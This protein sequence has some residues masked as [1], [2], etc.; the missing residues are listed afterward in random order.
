MKRYARL[1][2]NQAKHTDVPVFWA[3]DVTCR[4]A[5]SEFLSLTVLKIKVRCEHASGDHCT[6]PSVAFVSRQ[7]RAIR[8]GVVIINQSGCGMWEGLIRLPNNS[9]RTPS[10]TKIGA[11]PA[12]G[13]G[14][15][16]YVRRGWH[17]AC[18]SRLLERAL[19][20]FRN[21]ADDEPQACSG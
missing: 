4:R 20:S 3:R 17:A 1:N 11:A 5:R 15:T 14:E 7:F 19:G 2:N 21:A 9:L 12:A 18:G 16:W 10:E 6:A 13:A 8:G